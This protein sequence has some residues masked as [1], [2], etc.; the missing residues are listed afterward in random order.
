MDDLFT[1]VFLTGLH[2]VLGT[3]NREIVNLNFL[4]ILKGWPGGLAAD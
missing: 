3:K 4:N 1:D 2:Y